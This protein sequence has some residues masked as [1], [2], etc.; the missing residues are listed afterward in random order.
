MDIIKSTLNIQD[1]FTFFTTTIKNVSKL[2]NSLV[3]LCM[4]NADSNFGIVK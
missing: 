3:I 1:L 2:K 4:I